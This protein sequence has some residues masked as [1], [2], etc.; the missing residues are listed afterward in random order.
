VNILLIK[1]REFILDIK[2]SLKMEKEVMN[3]FEALKLASVFYEG[4]CLLECCT[5]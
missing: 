3:L 2:V 5:V 4:D 1:I